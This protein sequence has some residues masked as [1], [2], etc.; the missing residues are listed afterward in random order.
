MSVGSALIGCSRL[1]PLYPR[2]RFRLRPSC[3]HAA[4]VCVSLPACITRGGV[5]FSCT[6]PGRE[7]RKNEGMN[8]GRVRKK[9]GRKGGMTAVPP[10]LCFHYHVSISPQQR[11]GMY[12]TTKTLFKGEAVVC[13]LAR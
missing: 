11:M 13:L 3:S 1:A 7:R 9:E 6:T 12:K 10:K 5:C 4:S 2:P 8:E